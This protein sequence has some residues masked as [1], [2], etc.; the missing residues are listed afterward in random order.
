[1][2]FRAFI[3]TLESNGFVLDRTRGS[4]RLYV[5]EVRGRKHTVSVHVSRESDDIKPGTLAG[6]IR[7]SGLSKKRFR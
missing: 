5:G 1:M 4:A 2:K 3:R 6:M 7:Q